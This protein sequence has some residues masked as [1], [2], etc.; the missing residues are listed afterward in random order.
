MGFEVGGLQERV[1]AAVSRAL[2]VYLATLFRI[3][4]DAKTLL[5]AEAQAMTDDRFKRVC[6]L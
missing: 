2:L 3:E 4:K 1:S 5:P 6:D